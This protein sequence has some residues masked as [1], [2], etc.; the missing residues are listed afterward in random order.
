MAQGAFTHAVNAHD[1]AAGWVGTDNATVGLHPVGG[2]VEALFS[3]QKW[4]RRLQG[5]ETKVFAIGQ[6]KFT[7]AQI[8]TVTHRHIA[9]AMAVDSLDADGEVVQLELV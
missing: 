1:Q 9:G 7:A 5:I 3:R 4:Q 8:E 6:R 2:V